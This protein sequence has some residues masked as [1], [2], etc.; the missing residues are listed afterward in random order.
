M[1]HATLHE[2]VDAGRRRFVGTMMMGGGLALALRT[3]AGPTPAEAAGLVKVEMKILTGKMIGRPGWPQFMPG[4][5]SVPAHRPVEVTVRCY[6]DGNAQIPG[7][8]NKA[9]GTQDNMFRLIDA[10]PAK[11]AEHDGT[12]VHAIPVK[13][14]AHTF[15]VNGEDFFLNVPM[16]VRSTMIF[17]FTAPKP[18]AYP[19]QCMA[20]CGTGA[21]GWAGAMMTRGW[22]QGVMTVL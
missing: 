10:I 1:L 12:L 19:W 5:F 15:T 22:M 14:V 16:R 2:P 8:Y 21:G 3:I 6:D 9:S 20:A 13:E 18:G 17:R 7:G 4:G 11:I